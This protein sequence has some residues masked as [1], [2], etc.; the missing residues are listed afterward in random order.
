M[1][2]GV[3]G[4]SGP[5]SYAF[6]TVELPKRGKLPR[7]PSFE[8]HAFPK[9]IVNP[10]AIAHAEE[11]EAAGRVDRK[12]LGGA[13]GPAS[14]LSAIGAVPVELPYK[15]D[16]PTV[17]DFEHRAMNGP[18]E[19]EEGPQDEEMNGG[20]RL[21]LGSSGGPDSWQRWGGK[22]DYEKVWQMQQPALPRGKRE[23]HGGARKLQEGGCVPETTC[24]CCEP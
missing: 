22:P 7:E 9:W 14:E 23:T 10:A 5:G 19:E 12:L 24:I 6:G 3:D 1:H 15:G 2:A 21:L 8:R 17:P 16:L 11:E 20:A 13:T 4:D 18:I